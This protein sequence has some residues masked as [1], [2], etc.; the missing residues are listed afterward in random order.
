MFIA[1]M[2]SYGWDAEYVGVDGIVTCM[3]VFLRYEQHLYGIHVPFNG[4]ATNDLGMTEFVK[5][6]KQK[7][8]GG[9]FIGGLK[10][11]EL[12]AVVNGTPRGDVTA[13]IKGYCK[14]LG[15]SSALVFRLN[16][17]LGQNEGNH[18]AAAILCERLSK[19]SSSTIKYKKHSEANWQKEIGRVR[20]GWYNNDSFTDVLYTNPAGLGWHIADDTN[21]TIT[22]VRA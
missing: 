2:Y 18:D 13:D 21:S 4:Q 19:K 17:H 3:G 5:Y 20:E 10:G 9:A 14:G 7:T 22:E 16:K 8:K 15:L 12:I 11:A 6:V 1:T